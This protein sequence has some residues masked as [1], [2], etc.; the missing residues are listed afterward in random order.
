MRAGG[1]V[2]VMRGERRGAVGKQKDIRVGD[3][4]KVRWICL[5]FRQKQN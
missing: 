2:G 1:Y 3:G 4:Q 5:E